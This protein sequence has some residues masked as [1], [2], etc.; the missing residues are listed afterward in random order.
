MQHIGYIM[1]GN[2]TWAKEHSLPVFEGHRQGYENAIKIL[3]YTKARNIPFVTLWALSDD[4][5]KKRDARE[6]EYLFELLSRGILH[7]AKESNKNNIRLLCIGDRTLLPEKCRKNIKKAEE[8]TQNNTSM[9]AIIAVAYGGREE[10][11]RAL[12]SEAS[13]GT[14]MH[15]I[16]EDD[17]LSS[18]ES[19][20]FPPPDFIIRTG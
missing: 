12:H 6:L 19:A 10:I 5:I 11:I 15:R 18:L 4:N 14:D 7:L 2:R 9:T 1:D 20:Q 13:K 17:I 3:N 8:L 16:T